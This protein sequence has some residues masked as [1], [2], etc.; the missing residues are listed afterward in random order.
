MGKASS[1]KKVARAARAGGRSS[2]SKQRNLL[3]PAAIGV[4]ILLGTGLIA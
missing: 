1:S 4:I 2:G 3:F